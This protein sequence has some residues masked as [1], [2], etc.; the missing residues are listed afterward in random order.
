MFFVKYAFERNLIPP[1]VR[2][3]IGFITGA[4]LLVGGVLTHRNKAY[5]VLGQTLCASGTLILYGVTFAA[6]TLYQFPAFGTVTTFLLMTLI[7]A[8]AF[9][10]ASLLEALSDEGRPPA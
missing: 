10:L 5:V 9:L 6:H 4:G 1:A 8:T 7:T 3:A 2:T